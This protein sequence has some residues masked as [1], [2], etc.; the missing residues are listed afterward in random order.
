MLVELFLA[1]WNETPDFIVAAAAGGEG[2][3]ADLTALR[4]SLAEKD[5]WNLGSVLGRFDALA[6]DAQEQLAFAQ[7]QDRRLRLTDD[8]VGAVT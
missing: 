5:A 2:C 8:S 1:K 6:H 4:T 7:D 3:V